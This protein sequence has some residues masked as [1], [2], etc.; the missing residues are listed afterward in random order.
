MGMVMVIVIELVMGM[1]PERI[2]CLNSFSSPAVC[3]V[4][5]SAV[6][7]CVLVVGMSLPGTEKIRSPHHR[8]DESLSC[9]SGNSSLQ[10]VS[11]L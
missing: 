8:D 5:V 11:P 2:S 6:P 9:H 3:V 7:V 1:V 4:C 10:M